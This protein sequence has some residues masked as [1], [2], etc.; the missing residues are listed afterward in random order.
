MN[1]TLL[2]AID[3]SDLRRFGALVFD[4]DDTLLMRRRNPGG[5]N[6]IYCE[7]ESAKLIPVLL[8]TG[9]RVGLITGHGWEQLAG[10]LISPLIEDTSHRYPE[11]SRS[12]LSNLFVYANRGATK[13]NFTDGEFFV[14]A[15][16]GDAFEID[17]MDSKAI[18]AVLAELSDRFMSEFTERRNWYFSEFDNFPFAELPP[19]IFGHE[20]VVIGLKPVPSA[21]FRSNGFG[22]SPRK[23]LV[24]RGL[25]A[26]ASLGLNEKYDLGESGRTSLEV[27][28]KSVSKSV[29]F[30]DLISTI[31]SDCLCSV[32]LVEGAS[33]YVGDE[34]TPLGNDWVIPIDFPRSLCLSVAPILAT[35]R[36]ANVIQLS[37]AS[38]YNDNGVADLIKFIESVLVGVDFSARL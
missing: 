12:I 27:I 20:N 3:L 36:P 25:K 10:R 1:K 14:D 28:K 30:N 2:S 16:Y 23:D 8:K 32:E 35:A 7:S 17:D 26:M 9:L 15:E 13:V 31:A 24:T 29:A 33:I 34:F 5:R 6:Q 18:I 21:A 11:K 38:D 4:V 19:R 37:D 22:P